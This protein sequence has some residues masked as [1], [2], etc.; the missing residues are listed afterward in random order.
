MFLRGFLTLAK[1]TEDV[2]ELS[3]VVA[4]LADAVKDMGAVFNKANE[5]SDRSCF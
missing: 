2:K 3:A 1:T 5:D 4:E